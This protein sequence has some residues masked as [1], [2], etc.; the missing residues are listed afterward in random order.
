MTG[1]EA[2]SHR[3]RIV[4]MQALSSRELPISD[5]ALTVHLNRCLGCRADGGSP[6]YRPTALAPQ[7]SER[8]VIFR[9]C[10]CRAL[11]WQRRCVLDP[12][13][14]TVTAGPSAQTGVAGS[15]CRRRDRHCQSGLHHANRCR[16]VHVPPSSPGRPPHRVAGSIV[17]KS[18]LLPWP[19][20]YVRHGGKLV[21]LHGKH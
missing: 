3:G 15:R 16:P 17:S 18:R 7:G 11:L 21:S 4:L 8:A 6:P 13:T 12:R 9:S 19:Q 10:R 2:D 20:R 1:D 5:K 14:G